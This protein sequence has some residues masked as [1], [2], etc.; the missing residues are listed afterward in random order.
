[1][2]TVDDCWLVEQWLNEKLCSSGAD[3][4]CMLVIGKHINMDHTEQEFEIER[5]HKIT[6]ETQ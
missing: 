3:H 6:A 5:R 1:M 2:S 4:R